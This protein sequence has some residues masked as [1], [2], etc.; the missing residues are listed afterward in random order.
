MST[1]NCTICLSE[2]CVPGVQCP[3]CKN[4]TCIK[5]EQQFIICPFCRTNLPIWFNRITSDTLCIRMNDIWNSIQKENLR[6]IKNKSLF[7]EIINGSA[8]NMNMVV[9]GDLDTEDYV[10]LLTITKQ[11]MYH[12]IH[13][14]YLVIDIENM[15][16]FFESFIEI[17]QDHIPEN[18][19]FSG[20]A[21]SS[22]E[23]DDWIN[24]AIDKLYNHHKKKVSEFRQ[25]EYTYRIRRLNSKSIKYRK[26]SRPKKN[27]NKRLQQYNKDGVH[28]NKY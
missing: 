10:D 5:C 3:T 16:D 20:I 17:I 12:Y 9:S 6:F 18:L 25:K 23:I 14:L 27:I 19:L 15:L 8:E 22:E 13:N 7:K 4:C 21:I 2:N 28:R 24:I 1:I 26:K 11:Y